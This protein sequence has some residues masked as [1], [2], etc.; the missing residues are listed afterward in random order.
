[1]IAA[2]HGSQECVCTFADHGAAQYHVQRVRHRG[3]LTRRPTRGCTRHEPLRC[4]IAGLYFSASRFVR[5]N[6]RPLDGTNGLP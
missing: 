1:M 3:I 4:C 2:L 5:V 6:R